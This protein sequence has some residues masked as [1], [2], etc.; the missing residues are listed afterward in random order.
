[1]E[2]KQEFIFTMEEGEI[3]KWKMDANIYNK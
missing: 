3:I 2:N 1:M